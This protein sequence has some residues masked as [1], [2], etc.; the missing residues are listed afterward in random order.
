MQVKERSNMHNIFFIIAA[1]LIMLYMLYSIRK[2]K[3]SVTNS[4]IWIIF[5]IILLILSI[6]PT[7][8][9][10]LANLLG[11]AYPPA[12]FLSITAVI[13]FIINFIQSKKIEDLHKKVIDLSQELSIIK[14]DQK[15]ESPRKKTNSKVD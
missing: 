4:F 14:G 7:S 5:C 8:L 12:L 1:L 2:N 11:I 10:W 3:L 6:W 13:L 15:P 9:D